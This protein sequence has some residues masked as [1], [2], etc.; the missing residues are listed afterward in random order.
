MFSAAYLIFH[1]L[2]ANQLAGGMDIHAGLVMRWLNQV[3]S[4]GHC[5]GPVPLFMFFSCPWRSLYL[6]HVMISG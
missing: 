5:A 4:Y 6:Q 2:L 3:G 1:R